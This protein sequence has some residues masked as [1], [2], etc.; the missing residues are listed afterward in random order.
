[1]RI[2]STFFAGVVEMIISYSSR[3]ASS[4]AARAACARSALSRSRSA[5][6]AQQISTTSKSMQW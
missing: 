6:A 5:I 2:T 1:L 3:T 4:P